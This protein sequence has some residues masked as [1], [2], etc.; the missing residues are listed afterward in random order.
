LTLKILIYKIMGEILNTIGINNIP[1]SVNN[2]PIRLNNILIS[3]AYAGYWTGDEACSGYA[4]VFN[5]TII[6]DDTFYVSQQGGWEY[7]F[8]GIINQT[9]NTL[10]IYPLASNNTG[11][12]IDDVFTISAPGY[13][14]I[15]IYVEQDGDSVATTSIC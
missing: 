6:P 4:I 10:T 9:N 12:I 3:D 14:S 1:I 11:S 15:Q 2:V 8:T 13:S 5:I 7:G